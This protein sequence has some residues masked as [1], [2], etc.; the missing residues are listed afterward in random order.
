MLSVCDSLNIS[1]LG[2][3]WYEEDRFSSMVTLC[4]PSP[5]FFLLRIVFSLINTLSP[6]FI[7]HIF[8]GINQFPLQ[9]KAVEC[10][11]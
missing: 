4:D 3:K 9:T 11:V 1:V 6:Y 8:Y 10:C 2:G 7:D 5:M